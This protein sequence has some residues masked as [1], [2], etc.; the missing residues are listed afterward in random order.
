[1]Y[2]S[3]RDEIVRRGKLVRDIIMTGW[4]ECNWGEIR[5]EG[6]SEREREKYWDDYAEGYKFDIMLRNWDWE[7]CFLV[8][9]DDIWRNICKYMILIKFYKIR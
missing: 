7:D 2:N 9:I 1:M 4:K 5:D 8:F 3:G 6:M